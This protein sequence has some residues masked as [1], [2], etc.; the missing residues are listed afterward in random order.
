[1]RDKTLR[2]VQFSV[3]L[4][5]EAIF[6][7]TPLG[8][9]PAL[10]PIVATLAMVPVVITALLLG[11]RAG[12]AM[13]ALTGIFSLMV[14]TFAPPTP[15]AAFVF[16]PFYS[17]GE[18]QG[19]FGSL[20]ICLV[21]RILTGTLAALAYAAL[22]RLWPQRDYLAL[23]LAAAAGSLVNTLGVVGGIW[24]FFGT[25]YSQLAGSAMV[26]IAGLT[27]LTS[28]LPEAVVCALLAPPVCRACRRFVKSGREEK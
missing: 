5:I 28:G 13:G 11:V 24:L 3:L 16:S 4:A 12:T 18:I 9:L 19:N 21:P 1:M 23:A 22:K 25:Q 10:G 26:T 15:L 7:F 17:L 6:C 2:L 8:S 27:V 14:W 20:L